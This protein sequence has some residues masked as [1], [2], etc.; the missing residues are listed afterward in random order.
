MTSGANNVSQDGF[1]TTTTAPSDDAVIDNDAE[2][3]NRIEFDLQS[4]KKKLRILQDLHDA[5]ISDTPPEVETQT[6]SHFGRLAGQSL[7]N[8]LMVELYAGSAN[9]SKACQRVGV[10]S[11]AVDKTTQRSTGTKIFRCDVTDPEDL[12]M[13]KNFLKA[14]KKHLA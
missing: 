14:E 1:V 6:D 11:V 5:K 12:A 7:S 8:I 9:L 2:G 10:R 4:A 13:L 3:I